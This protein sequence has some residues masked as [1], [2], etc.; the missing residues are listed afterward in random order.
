MHQK[1]TQDSTHLSERAYLRAPSWPSW[2]GRSAQCPLAVRCPGTQCRWGSAPSS[3]VASRVPLVPELPVPASAASCRRSAR[4]CCMTVRT[5]TLSCTRMRSCT[6]RWRRGCSAR[7][8]SAARCTASACTWPQRRTWTC[9]A[10]AC[11]VTG[12]SMSACGTLACTARCACTTTRARCSCTSSLRPASTSSAL[13]TSPGGGKRQFQK[14]RPKSNR[15]AISSKL[16]WV[17]FISL[18]FPGWSISWV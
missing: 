14:K 13:P 7:G 6:W 11:K 8:C 15:Q 5:W 12:C 1:T 10:W 2:S 9:T 18:E 17:Q 4:F 3:S 16:H